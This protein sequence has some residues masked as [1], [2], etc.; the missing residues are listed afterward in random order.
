MK[1]VVLAAPISNVVQL[2]DK[3][4]NYSVDVFRFLGAIAIVVLHTIDSTDFPP[5]FY[6]FLKISTRWAVPF[7]FLIS[8]YFF[9]Q[10]YRSYPEKALSKRLKNLIGVFISATIIYFFINL[11]IGYPL[12]STLSLYALTAGNYFH[13]WFIGSMIFGYLTMWFIL[14][15]Q[16]KQITLIC[17]IVSF[18]LLILATG[19]YASILG[20][21][22]LDIRF[23]RHLAAVPFLLIGFLCARNKITGTISWPVAALLALLG[24]GIQIAETFYLQIQFGL[25]PVSHDILIGTFLFSFS[26]FCLSMAI[27]KIKDN[28]LTRWGRNYSLLIYLYHPILIGSRHTNLHFFIG[29][30][31]LGWMRPIGIF[32]LCLLLIIMIHRFLPLFFRFANGTVWK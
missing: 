24:L 13:L 23:A 16:L 6:L 32:S 20:L 12:S 4:R 17:I 25:D 10:D 1:E 18:V 26:I 22:G 19:S 21:S 3:I 2:G 28:I 31:S 8:G 7:F 14:E 30:Y 27:I 11:Y 15:Q 5:L 29:D 9:E